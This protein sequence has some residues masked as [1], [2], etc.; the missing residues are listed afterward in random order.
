MEGMSMN[1]IAKNNHYKKEWKIYQ[2]HFLGQEAGPFLH[3]KHLACFFCLPF[4]EIFNR[5]R[6]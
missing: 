3:D 4:R 2:L 5:Q 1:D 6:I